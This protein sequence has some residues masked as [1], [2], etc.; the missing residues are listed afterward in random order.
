MSE[1]FRASL[2]VRNGWLTGKQGQ[3][4]LNYIHPSSHAK[5]RVPLCCGVLFVLSADYR[6]LSG[7]VLQERY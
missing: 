3:T 4:K 2:P 5:A 7:K 6:I 1:R